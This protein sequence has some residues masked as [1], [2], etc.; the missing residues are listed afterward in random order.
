MSY[1]V[2]DLE[3]DLRRANEWIDKLAAE[4]SLL[5]SQITVALAALDRIDDEVNNDLNKIRPLPMQE[6]FRKMCD[7][8]GDAYEALRD[9]IRDRYL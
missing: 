1:H 9:T 7:R 3:D 8:V 6:R 4:N 2:R 5:R